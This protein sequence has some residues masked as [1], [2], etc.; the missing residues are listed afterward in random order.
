MKPARTLLPFLLAYDFY[1]KINNHA[2]I[3][4]DHHGPLHYPHALMHSIIILCTHFL[5]TSDLIITDSQKMGF[6]W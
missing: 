3:T 2:T 5:T 6:F 4:R 1:N